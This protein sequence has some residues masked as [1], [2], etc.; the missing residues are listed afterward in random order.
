MKN[1]SKIFSNDV[2]NII[3]NKNI[4]NLKFN[5]IFCDPPF[6]NLDTLRLIK[7]L[8][9]NNILHK[10]GIII[11][12]RHKNTDEKMPNYFKL[13]DERKYGVSKIIF[14]KFSF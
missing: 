13:I 7:I 4:L 11:L 3:K 9:E 2:F 5:L 12:H 1:R 14:G 6:K 8:F 10:E